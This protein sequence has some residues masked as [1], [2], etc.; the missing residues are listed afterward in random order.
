MQD[1]YERQKELHERAVRENRDLSNA[2]TLE[3]NDLEARFN[4]L[5]GEK[6]AIK[7]FYS[8]PLKPIPVKD[9]FED[10]SRDAMKGVSKMRMSGDLA[11]EYRD[12]GNFFKNGMP[13]IE[14]RTLQKD[15]DSSGGFSVTSEI[16][17]A[18][19]FHDLDN[20]VFVRNYA[21]K[22]T[23]DRAD[24]VG[25][26][27][28]D[29]D[30]SDLTFT[31]EIT[32]ASLDTSMRFGKRALRPTRLA[33]GIK[34]S[35]DLLNLSAADMADFIVSRLVYKLA[36]TEENA[37]LT[38]S[39]AAGNPLGLFTRSADGVSAS[40]DVTTGNT[41]TAITADGLINC[42]YA[43]KSQYLNSPSCFWV[44][45]RDVLKMIR[46]L[47]DGEG[48]YL[49]QSGLGGSPST[50]LGKAYLLSEY[51]PSTLT[52]G[53]RVGLIGDLRFYGIAEYGQFSLQVLKELYSL[54]NCDAFVINHHVDAMP[55][56]ATA[57]SCVT[58][59]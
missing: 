13:G 34:V 59:A 22:F 49:W 5:H 47:K 36:V 6:M 30:A 29:V 44:F 24:G 8:Q 45:H 14:T 7:S 3:W 16:V 53:S 50:I 10:E 25:I 2:E 38:G 40:R 39:G 58:L 56:I 43:L 26:P 48:Q 1:I 20:A 57:F 17:N 51:A 41:T 27:V 11:R 52:S 54:E 19:I 31:G 37:F 46:K 18:K 28:L 9:G 33:K 55:L 42:M 4:Q 15:I 23:V 35:R 32:S 21:E 12:L